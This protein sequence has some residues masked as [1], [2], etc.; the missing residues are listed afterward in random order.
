MQF[1]GKMNMGNLG[2]E[3]HHADG[4]SWPWTAAHQICIDTADVYSHRES[5]TL[6]GNALKGIRKRSCWPQG[7]A[8]DV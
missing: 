3:E 8:S 7:P 6:L 2:Q 5:E 1:G 4:E